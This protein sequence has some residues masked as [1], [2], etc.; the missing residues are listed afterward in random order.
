M[1]RYYKRI[2]PKYPQLPALCQFHDSLTNK[3]VKALLADWIEKTKDTD[4]YGL[5]EKISR[6]EFA[7]LQDMVPH[8]VKIG[9][10]EKEVQ[11]EMPVE[12]VDIT[13]LPFADD[14]T[15][16]IEYGELKEVVKRIARYEVIILS[17]DAE[18]EH[19]RGTEFAKTEEKYKRFLK[20][21]T[22]KYGEFEPFKSEELDE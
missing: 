19:E 2:H 6:A 14:E 3:Q 10:P 13:E 4:D 11:D 21:Y 18:L 7:G 17:M 8:S 1:P 5:P 15:V 20:R 9:W 12:R 16:G 22:D